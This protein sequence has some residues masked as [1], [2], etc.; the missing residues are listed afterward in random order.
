MHQSQSI[1]RRTILRQ[2]D[3]PD[4]ESVEIEK[5]NGKGPFILWYKNSIACVIASIQIA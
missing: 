4:I 2:Q 1:S 3:I 5:N